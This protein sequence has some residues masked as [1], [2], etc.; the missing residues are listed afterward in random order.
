MAGLALIATLPL[1]ALLSPRAA[2]QVALGD[3][4]ATASGQ[5]TSLYDD[6][7]GNLGGSDAHS[8]GFA[9]R[10][11][12]SG[13]Y[14]NP[15]F[16][17]FNL[18]PYYG[19]SQDNSDMQSISDASGYN[20]TLNIFKGSHFPGVVTFDQTWNST[21]AFG[22]PDV[23]GLATK[24]NSHGL[25][26]VWSA[27]LPGLPT[28]SVGY[29]DTGGTSS[30]LG[31]DES[32]ASSTKNFNLGSTYTIGSFYLTGGFIHLNTD[33]NV[34]GLEDGESETARGS[35]NQYRLTGQG[36]IPYRTSSASLSLGRD[37]YSDDD[38]LGGTNYGTTD[39]VNGNLN[40]AFPRAPVQ[41]TTNYTDNLLGS[42]EQQLVNNGE[43]PL[44]G[45]NSP[46]SRSVTVE[47]STF[48][49]VL[50]RTLV[51][52][53]VSR[54]QQFFDG[55]NFG[56]TQ[57][58]VNVSYNFLHTLKGLMFYGGLVESAT[59]QG[60]T[61]MG[62]IGNVSYNRYMGKWEINSFALYNQ[63][64][65]TLLVMYTTSTLNYGGTIKRELPHDMRWV[66]V[67]NLVRSVFEQ[68]A[69]T[70]SHG[71]SFTTMLIWSRASVSGIY[72]KSDGTSILTSTGLVTSPVPGSV[73]GA[74]NSILYAG[75]S[76]GANVSVFPVKHMAISAAWSKSLSDTTSSSLLTNSG[77]TNYYGL[78]TY[79]Y[80]KLLFQAGFTKFNQSISTSG[81]PPTMLTSYSFGISR[82]F[83][84]F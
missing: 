61:R 32:T 60:N 1:W 20:G 43:V 28:L 23:S 70:A 19:R 68:T 4:H 55:D 63:D 9:G 8:L 64:V 2:A 22:I 44:A 81:T 59:Q 42:I 83:K 25:N 49:N 36:R 65:E 51:G 79:E 52:A 75:S 34:G 33:V 53:Y 41:V 47:A 18:L 76:Y 35:S 57:V 74:G 37:T 11:V 66:A 15:N 21:G 7:F 10:G 58:G 31:S 6:T 50:P 84:G 71:E 26:V 39:T 80:R 29:G 24:N 72:T 17:S 48:V 38:T 54:T 45:L 13:D 77:N 82:W 5:L 16:L 12:I 46:E 27:L 56:V 67:A 14:Y 40:L 30:L 69:G 3:L 78:A 73:L 62:F